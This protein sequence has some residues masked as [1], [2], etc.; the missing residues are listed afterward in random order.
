MP[1]SAPYSVVNCRPGRM[2][3]L[4]IDSNADGFVLAMHFKPTINATSTQ[5]IF[6]ISDAQIPY[7]PYLSAQYDPATKLITVLIHQTG[8]APIQTTAPLTAG[9]PHLTYI[10]PNFS[11]LY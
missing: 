9:V 5:T 7:D 1:D 10:F 6:G 4:N 2:L 11:P 3:S 8:G